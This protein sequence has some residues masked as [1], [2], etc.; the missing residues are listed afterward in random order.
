MMVRLRA[1]LTSEEELVFSKAVGLASL[2]PSL[3][4]AREARYRRLPL[5]AVQL[6]RP[7]PPSHLILKTKCE[8]A[9]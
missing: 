3:A 9:W 8:G 2:W 6:H 7:R 5:V 4:R 1:L